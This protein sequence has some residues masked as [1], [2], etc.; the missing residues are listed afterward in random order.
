M[1]DACREVIVTKKAKEGEVIELTVPKEEEVIVSNEEEVTVKNEG[2]ATVTNE[3]TKTEEELEV[4]CN[5]NFGGGKH[6]LYFC[7][8]GKQTKVKK[9]QGDVELYEWLRYNRNEESKSK[10][11]YPACLEDGFNFGLS[12]NKMYVYSNLKY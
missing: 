10:L 7:E 8:K 5:K 9:T 3:D 12:L 6:I 1:N 4:T 2:E 11:T